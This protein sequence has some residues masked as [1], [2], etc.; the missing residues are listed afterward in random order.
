MSIKKYL[1]FSILFTIA[2][3]IINYSFRFSLC[4]LN[5]PSCINLFH[6]I[7]EPILYGGIAL[8]IVFFLLLFTRE[9]AF[10]AWR[11]FAIWYVPIAALIMA[12]YPTPQGGF[13]VFDPD[14]STVSYYL[15]VVYV[16]ASALIIAV[17]FFKQK[18]A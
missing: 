5:D 6:R 10:S 17:Q 18:R 2:G 11:K 9:Y 15:S 3:S 7:G 4:S 1:L 8:S 13:F 14:P 12:F 16:V